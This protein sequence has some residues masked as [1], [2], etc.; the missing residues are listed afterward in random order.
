MRDGN[1][2]YVGDLQDERV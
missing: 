1:L 2:L